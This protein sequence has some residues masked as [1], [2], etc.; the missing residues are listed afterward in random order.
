M[1][2][3]VGSL[4]PSVTAMV[5]LVVITLVGL[6]YRSYNLDSKSLW[7]DEIGQVLAS[8]DG[9]VAAIPGAVPLDYEIT[10]IV[11][12]TLGQGESALRLSAVI[13]GTAAI[14]LIYWLGV[15]LFASRLVGLVSATLLAF[16]PAAIQYSQEVRWYSL[17]AALALLV[18]DLVLLAVRKR[19]ILYWIAVAVALL[20]AATTAVHHALTIMAIFIAL[21]LMW[22]YE[23]FFPNE[24]ESGV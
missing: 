21:F 22:L 2:R 19:R 9:F 6:G 23:H 17:S 12:R 11:V 20:L 18:V 10:H 24:D 14:L 7:E 3:F 15:S 5:L 16:N 4:N 13:W 8:R 1:K